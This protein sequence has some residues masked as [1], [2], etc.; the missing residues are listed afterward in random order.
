MESRSCVDPLTGEP[1][2]AYRRKDGYERERESALG[3]LYTDPREAYRGALG[4][5]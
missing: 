5:L 3:L 1:S 2:E 4:S